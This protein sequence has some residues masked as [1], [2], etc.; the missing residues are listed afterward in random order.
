[1]AA[2]DDVVARFGGSKTPELQKL[3]AIAM[4]NKGTALGRAGDAEARIA[5]YDDV[6]TQFG[7]SEAPELQEEVARSF[8]FKAST[9][10][11]VGEMDSALSTCDEIDRWL[12]SVAD[13]GAPDGGWWTMAKG[14]AAGVRA[15]A[16]AV[17]G[18]RQAAIEALRSAY[19][20]SEPGDNL[21]MKLL[22]LSAIELAAGGAS[23]GDMVDALAR[24]RA[25]AG[26]LAPLLVALR[27][28]AGGTVRVP[29]EMLEVA[30]DI[31]KKIEER[32][33]ARNAGGK[34]ATYE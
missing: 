1:M 25:K 12:D 21:T 34:S 15:A 11:A 2:Y 20:M 22:V 23:P 13:K 17:H 33:A 18:R 10:Y 8:L 29:T 3:V 30:D 9:Q 24:D 7:S 28:R 26:A 16:L 14:T 32:K 19:A 6:V 27:R 5:A 31:D 4:F